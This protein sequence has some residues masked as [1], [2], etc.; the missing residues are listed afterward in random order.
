MTGPQA[1]ARGAAGAALTALPR[2]AE[3]ARPAGARENAEADATK[4]ARATAAFVNMMR[5][6]LDREA[7]Y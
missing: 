5:V 4:A 6:S 7:T 1:R 2:K 3:G